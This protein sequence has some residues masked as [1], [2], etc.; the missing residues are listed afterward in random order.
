MGERNRPAVTKEGEEV[1]KSFSSCPIPSWV[2]LLQEAKRSTTT[3]VEVKSSK[4][5]KLTVGFHP[6]DT[7][8]RQIGKRRKTSI[9]TGRRPPDRF[10][11]SHRRSNVTETVFLALL[12]HFH[13]NRSP[14]CASPQM[15]G[16]SRPKRMSSSLPLVIVTLSVHLHWRYADGKIVRRTPHIHCFKGSRVNEVGG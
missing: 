5:K 3:A 1:I 14:Y 15:R 13:I 12:S 16:C 4:A 11:W 2:G 8:W 7:P 6:P 9:L 10:A